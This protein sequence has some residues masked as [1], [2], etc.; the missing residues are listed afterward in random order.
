[1]LIYTS[2]NLFDLNRHFLTRALFNLYYEDGVVEAKLEEL[3]RGIRN[4]P[5]WF[6]GI[7]RDALKSGQDI[8]EALDGNARYLLY[9]SPGLYFDEF[10]QIEVPSCRNSR[11][12][13]VLP[14]VKDRKREK[15][16]QQM[17]RDQKWLTSIKE[18]AKAS[19]ISV[20]DAI[21]RDLDWILKK[22]D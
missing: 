14:Q 9:G 21:E 3:K 18:K 5:D 22:V 15:Y 6:A 12:A 11:I 4:T 7:E 17:L 16:R 8:E 1:M 20:E 19:N 2:C 10:N 13:K